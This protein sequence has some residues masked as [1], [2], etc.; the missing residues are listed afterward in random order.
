M[1]YQG[2][3]GFLHF[4][5]GLQKMAEIVYVLTNEAM[6][7]M[8]KVG[9]T[10]T[11]VEQRIKELD[12]TSLPLPFQC[13]YAAEVNDSAMVEGRL[14]RIFSDKRIRSNREFFRID[15]NQVREAIMLAELKE[16][17]PKSDVFLDASDA[18]AIQ[19]A[20][21][22]EERRSRIRFSEL[23]ILIGSTLTFAKN[24]ELKCSVVADGKVEFQGENMSPSAAAL[25]AIRDLGYNWSAASGSD[26]WE[27]ESETLSARRL[28][29]EDE[30]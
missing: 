17:T 8:V 20:V 27:Y 29:L 23:G 15:A 14:H 16:V 19:K 6:Q 25:K 12:N 11:S 7:G 30:Q 22:S 3:V 9:R 1:Q 2:C 21:T 28:R 4:V 26:F 24:P 18:Q 10:T 13:F 5:F